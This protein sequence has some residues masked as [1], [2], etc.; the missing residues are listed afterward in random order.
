[1]KN[2]PTCGKE[3]PGESEYCPKCGKRIDGKKQCPVCNAWI[4]PNDGFC[5][6]C[7]KRQS[8]KA[9]AG[10]TE[11]RPAQRS[12]AQRRYYYSENKPLSGGMVGFVMA[13]F[14]SLVGLIL[15]LCLG[16]AEARH[17]ATITFVVEVVIGIVLGVI[18]GVL[19]CAMIA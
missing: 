6:V 4:G 17:A 16:D 2:C 7:G 3:I 14:L 1:M 15:V 9:E 11:C 19:T 5:P 13:F 18:L 8:P 10:S 12:A